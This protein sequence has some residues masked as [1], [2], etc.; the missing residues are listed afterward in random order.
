MQPCRPREGGRGYCWEGVRRNVLWQEGVEFIA[1]TPPKAG[2][3]WQM[4]KHK[5]LPALVIPYAIAISE[6]RG[7]KSRGGVGREGALRR[8]E[9]ELLATINR[10]HLVTCSPYPSRNL[11]HL[12]GRLKKPKDIDSEP[13]PGPQNWMGSSHLSPGLQS[14]LLCFLI[15]F[16]IKSLAFPNQ[17]TNSKGRPGIFHS[18]FP[19][20][21]SQ[22]GLR[23][24]THIWVPFQEGTLLIS[25]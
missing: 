9:Q 3:F 2:C 19:D 16:C 13:L 20:Y 17:I 5:S 7:W 11:S 25:S 22:A 24:A 15:M 1:P 18:S 12:N 21:W 4:A 23:T 14:V 8:P 10:S 6:G